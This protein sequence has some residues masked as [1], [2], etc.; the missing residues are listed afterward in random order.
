[1]SWEQF[2]KLNLYIHE[3]SGAK[4]VL[5]VTRNYPYKE[6]YTHVLGY[7]SRASISDINENET[8]K[9]NHVPGLRV[10]KI[11][12]EKTF[13]NE[14]IG[15]NGVQ[16]YEVNAYGK[17][18][19]Q[20]NH[21]EGETGKNITLTIDSEIQKFSNVSKVSK[22]SQKILRNSPNKTKMLQ[23][24]QSFGRGNFGAGRTFFLRRE[25]AAGELRHALE[26]E[27]EGFPVDDMPVEHVELREGHRVQRPQDARHRQKVPRGFDH[28]PSPGESRPVADGP[29][30]AAHAVGA[31]L[32]VVVDELRQRLEGPVG[33]DG[34]VGGD[35]D[36]PDRRHG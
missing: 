32:E 11:G 10:G 29:G 15:T 17:R 20:L 4:P 36:R 31:R 19:S 2:S 7:V 23:S 13:E 9:K 6:N 28:H 25:G 35:G 24:F 21:S 27:R 18:I 8:I 30:D 5:S 1:M 22:T 14:L 33:A 26:L 34:G 12:L 3:L 16:R